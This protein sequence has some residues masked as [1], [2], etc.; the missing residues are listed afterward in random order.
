[1]Y[2]N[3]TDIL[4]ISY[5]YIQKKLG[6]TYIPSVSQEVYSPSHSFEK[7]AINLKRIRTSHTI[8]GFIPLWI[9]KALSILE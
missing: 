9:L 6:I 7:S 1:M 2:Y 4:T 3:L 5:I 8:L